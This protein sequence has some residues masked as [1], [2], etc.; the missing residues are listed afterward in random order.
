[1]KHKDR[2]REDYLRKYLNQ[3]IHNVLLYDLIINVD[4]ISYEQAAVI[5]GE[6]LFK[7]LEKPSKGAIPWVKNFQESC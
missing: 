7:K 4:N 1:M 6:A 2:E 5:I 3:D